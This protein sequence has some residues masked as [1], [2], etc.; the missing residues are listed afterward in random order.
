MITF[1]QKEIEFIES[2]EECRLATSHDDI[3][4]VKPVSYIYEKNEFLIA[5]D[6]ET[7][8]FKNLKTNHRVALVIDA[9]K[10]GNHKAVLIQGKGEII[11]SGDEFKKNYQKFYNKFEWVRRDPWKENEAPF[12]KITPITKTSWGL[13]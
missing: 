7:R 11:E 10:P 6:Y 1:N 13:N 12:I 8:S 2:H 5:T 4:H 9:Y 3:P